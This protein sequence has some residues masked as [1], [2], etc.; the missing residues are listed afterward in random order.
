MAWPILW[1]G[2]LLSLSFYIQNIHL[3]HFPQVETKFYLILCGQTLA[4]LKRSPPFCFLWAHLDAHW[5][6]SAHCNLFFSFY[7]VPAIRLSFLPFLHR[8]FLEH[9]FS[10]SYQKDDQK[11]ISHLSFSPHF[12]PYLLKWRCVSLSEEVAQCLDKGG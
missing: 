2:P 12:F 4:E 3:I 11:V 5:W 7:P 6:V 10:F 1:A 8:F 9:R